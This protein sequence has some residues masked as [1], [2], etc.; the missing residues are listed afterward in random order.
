MQTHHYNKYALKNNGL[1]NNL[2]RYMLTGVSVLVLTSCLPEQSS[3]QYNAAVKNQHTQAQSYAQAIHQYSSRSYNAFV[4]RGDWIDQ[5]ITA[6]EVL[7]LNGTSS[8]YISSAYC[9]DDG[10]KHYH[11]TWFNSPDSSGQL[12]LK[13]LGSGS[14]G[15][16]STNVQKLVNDSALAISGDN[17]AIQFQNGNNLTLSSSCNSEINIPENSVVVAYELEPPQTADIASSKILYRTTACPDGEQGTIVGSISVDHTTD[18]GLRVNGRPYAS[19]QDIISDNSLPW[20]ETDNCQVKQATLNYAPEIGTASAI[21]IGTTAAGTDIAAALE[22]HLDD[23]DCRKLRELDEQTDSTTDIADTCSEGNSVTVLNR[24]TITQIDSLPPETLTYGCMP[25]TGAGTSTVNLDNSYTGVPTQYHGLNALLNVGEYLSS[26]SVEVTKTTSRH[27]ATIDRNGTLEEKIVNS[28]D[29]EGQSIQCRAANAVRISCN[30]IF[31]G[32]HSVTGT[33]P[34]Y[35]A[36]A[37]VNGW[38]NPQTLEPNP[39]I[40][41][42][43]SYDSSD[44]MNCTVAERRVNNLGCPSGESGIRSEVEERIAT[45]TNPSQNLASSWGSY[46]VVTTTDTCAPFFA[47]GGGGGGGGGT[48]I[49]VDGDGQADFS[50]SHAA[51]QAGFSG[52]Q[53]VSADPHEGASG[54]HGGTTTSGI[55]YDGASSNSSDGGKV[56]CTYFYIKGWLPE[57]IY[58]AD[59]LYAKLYVSDNTKNGYHYWAVPMVKWLLE[60]E[61]PIAEKFIFFWVNAWAHQMAYDMGTISKPSYLGTAMKIIGEPLCNLIGRFVDATDYRRLWQGI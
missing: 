3:Q 55:S 41:T 48:G 54:W 12:S 46:S 34:R 21:R 52:G 45:I 26:G 11:L 19:E 47:G 22:T 39:E 37:T 7:T 8:D 53:T 58:E 60:K 13:G 10:G 51:E 25:R 36:V 43:Y 24:T 59:S 56:L 42:P 49:D 33:G 4:S 23:I 5:T 32:F 17:N 9:L 14:N 6:P 50:S 40:L 28:V 20:S 1:P 27:R 31:T 2:R 35:R 57:N 61:R 18:G 38:L 16:I 29:L 44:P 15:L 30:E